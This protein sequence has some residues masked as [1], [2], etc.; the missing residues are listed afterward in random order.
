[1]R[2]CSS[3]KRLAAG[4]SAVLLPFG[5]LAEDAFA[6]T[7]T[8][9]AEVIR[10][11]TNTAEAS[12]QFEG[13]QRETVS[14]TVEFD[15]TLPPPA[16]RAFR[17]TPQGNVDLSFRA[18]LCAASG[19]TPASG[20]GGAPPSTI[21]LSPQEGMVE[22]TST[23]RPGQTLLFE[24]TAL[25]AN[26]DRNAEDRLSVT[27]TTSTGDEETLTIF[28]TGPNTG[29]FVGQIGTARI[30]PLPAAGDCQ[31]SIN[32]GANISIEAR[33]P[34]ETSV[35]VETRVEVLADP[36]GV[37][38]D[39]ETGEPVSG[40]RVSLVD[41]VTGAPA[42]VFAE[43][44][45]TPWPSTVISG[46]PI[47]YGNGLIQIQAPG[48]FWFPLTNLGDYRL[49]I[50]PP[51]PY[52]APSVVAPASLAQLRRPDGRAFVILDASFGEVFTLTDPTPV[53]V[54]IPL[55]RPGTDIGLV[56]TASRDRVQPGDVVFYAI[57]ATNQDPSRPKRGV[58]L[59]DTPS[60][61]LRFRPETVRVN[62]AEAGDNVQF[63]PDGSTLTIALG[64]LAGGESVRVTYAM[65]VRPDANPGPAINEAVTVD[66]LGRVTRAGAVVDVERE[67]I[68][69]RMTIIGRITAGPCSVRD[70]RD[71]PRPGVPG[72]RVVM[73]DGS[74]AITDADGRYHFEGVVPGT[75]VVAVARMTVPEGGKLVNCHR[76][77]RNAGSASSRFVIGQGGTLAVAD[78]HIE[79]P[80]LS[81]ADTDQAVA[82]LVGETRPEGAT[83]HA[84][85]AIA[86]G[87]GRPNI[88][89][90]TR[91]LGDDTLT[92]AGLPATTV[93]AATRAAPSYAPNTDWIALG[94]GE[95][96]FLTPGVTANPRAPAI[97]VAIRHRRGQTIKLRVNGEEVSG[98][99]F[100]G[101]LTPA[102]GRF[103]VSTWRGIVLEGEHT[104]L[105][106]DVVNSFGGVNETF[107]REV[108]FTTTPTRVEL[109]P[110]LSNLVADGRTRPVVAIR[111][112]DRN[113]RPLREGVSGNFT[114]NAPYESAEQIDRQQLNQLTGFTPSQARWVVEGTDGIARIEL[115]PTMV[116]GSLRLDFDFNDGELV[117]EQQLE[118]WVVPGDIEWT[119]VGLAEGT[120]GAR[121]VAENMERE[122]RFDSDLGD[123][124]RV[125]LYA[126]GRILGK[127]LTT[128]AY[129]S[130]KQREDQR[131]L[132][133][134]DPNAYYTVFA[135]ASSR[136]F[137]AASREK[138]YVRIETAT[139]YA[140]YGDFETAFDQT[141]L[142]RYN[143][144][145]TGVKAEAR[146]GQFKASG[147]AAD[148]STRLQR[149]E[150][151]GQGITGPYDLGS[152]RILA[153]SDR[154]TI[155]VRDRFRPEQI[156]NTITLT[157]FLD[158][159]IDLL[160][161]TLT[162]TRPVLSRDENL[163]P[164]FIIT[165]FETDG[166]GDGEF[167]AGLRTDWTSE[168][169]RV[170]IGANAITDKGEG[171]RTDLGTLDLRANI[172]NNTE[173]RGEV[174]L[175][176]SE[177]ETATGWLAEV[178]HQTGKVDILAYAR[179]LDQ[180]Y[181]IGQQNGVDLGR[182]RIGV[183]GRVFLGDN[184]SVLG[185]VWQDDSLSDTSRRRAA[186][187]QL[188]L[189]RADTD[190]RVGLTHFNDRL[191]DGTTNTSTVLEGG[192]TK[193]LLNN[194]LELSA[195]TAIALDEAESLDLP[196]RHR[197]GA[198]YAIANGVRLVGTYEIADGE[199]IDAR[200]LRGGIELTPWQGGQVI[201][202]LGQES[203]GELG[204]RTFAAFGL[205]QTLQ[206]TPE[207]TIDATIDGNRTLN[208]AP[209]A[210]DLINVAQPAASGGQLTGG[211][212]F[213]DF[214]AVTFGGAWRKDRW[215]LTAR[216]EYR[217]GEQADR[218]G[219]TFGGI[220]QLGEGSIVGTGITWTRAEDELG[221]EVEIMDAS[222]A[223]AHRPDAS[224]IA[225]LGK[226]EYRSDKVTG[227]I[228]G[229]AGGA[230]ASALIVDGDAISRRVVASWSTNWSPRDY[231][232]DENG[233]TRQTRRNEFGLFLG[234]RYNFD[235]FE[236]TEF[237]GTTAFVGADARIGIGEKFEIGASATVR[238]NLED[239]VT[240]FSYGPTI[241]FT[242]V[243][244]MLVTVG[245]NV[246]GFRDGDFSEARNTD[247]GVFAAVRL[248]FDTSSFDFLGLG[249]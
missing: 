170:R 87:S 135:D 175:S 37:V 77:T 16:I 205:A 196:A 79:F 60:S 224:E 220:R 126:K 82:N 173:V 110:E 70:T 174:A 73:E 38:F 155:E 213:E 178:Q 195:S 29:V 22:V 66:T 160:T 51:E 211:Q 45:V 150:I 192:V 81:I 237:S 190:F 208:G 159:D 231:D 43:D 34:N 91:Q 241:G 7:N 92:G 121:S 238:A 127:F 137:D 141:R 182:R 25:A 134:L 239:N 103:A 41:A 100:D 200:T 152:R 249:R 167:N 57:T 151:Q 240:S 122:G 61:S 158:Y 144:T 20:G 156:V 214:T 234:G 215:S 28:E 11:I 97:R 153:N 226:L 194:S 148:I 179:Q 32:D 85:N 93:E 164:Q 4:L 120:V 168:N 187:T 184:L 1:M 10:T 130:A 147:F 201:T 157:R 83:A 89:R 162:F 172:G 218:Y 104:L 15:V 27:I 163:N 171:A 227:G 101:T 243:D 86:G 95:D 221:P 186:Q 49:V 232:D 50:E 119:I 193:R 230:G 75:H 223:F 35:L 12:W 99:S 2:V 14:N 117:R 107:T 180:D 108:F 138:L 94:D 31:L 146:V 188:N 56:K 98:L 132:G 115:A 131:V 68:A 112:L 18:P 161:G 40:A 88:D 113:N 23:I 106:A 142:A 154:V 111:V 114:L 165:E 44:G 235:E 13:R 76:D 69:D 136:R 5:V 71:N 58:V 246:E 181:G 52:S 105:E 84:L 90:A 169:G 39:S 219:A 139:F 245:Y 102:E 177:G 53:Q 189:T 9:D 216:G 207:F 46:E 3:L 166:F 129:D 133:Q 183:D 209:D 30:P 143:R 8:N 62:G 48:E 19:Q 198:R 242:P 63:A 21:E 80:E 118:T 65:T 36:F 59:T 225:M 140:L 74:Y 145:A 185:S 244:G 236:G 128:I 247:K 191:I 17:S 123:D 202:S 24:I 54:D 124:A 212:L 228:A 55:D 116:S 109:V 149:R 125:A 26:V 176:R 33:L 199:N 229:Q 233:I 197:I 72:V 210:T 42:T 217:D 96:G 248:K 204:N 6:Q 64:D 67:T 47:A 203:I 78:F 206:L 222:V